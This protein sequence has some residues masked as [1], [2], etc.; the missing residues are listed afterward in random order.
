MKYINFRRLLVIGF[1]LTG[2]AFSAQT[3]AEEGCYSDPDMKDTF[4]TIYGGASLECPSAGSFDECSVTISKKGIPDY[5]NCQGD[6][7]VTVEIIESGEEDAGKIHWTSNDGID[8]VLTDSAQGGKG[9]L[10]SNGTDKFEGFAGYEKSTGGFFPPTKVV[11]CSDAFAEYSSAA[12]PV[13]KVEE[14]VIGSGASKEI[15]GVKF[16]CPLVP[17][18]ETRTIIVSKDTTCAGFGTAQECSNVPGFGFTDDAT[19]ILDF[20]NVCQCVGGVGTSGQVVDKDECD[21]N[22]DADGLL[23]PRCIGENTE[24]NNNPI[25]ITIQ[26]PK[27]FTVGGFTRCF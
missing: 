27:C 26:Q 23:V 10:T 11:F 4:T 24:I 17:D 15:H 12:P 18:G 7:D 22:P 14:C 6:L 20:N 9:C 2:L 3:L 13:A 5:S 25:V 8:A 16:S 21:P 1:T 19:G